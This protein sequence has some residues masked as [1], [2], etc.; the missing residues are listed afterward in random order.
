M[1]G[2]R[3]ILHRKRIGRLLLTLAGL[4]LVW[5]LSASGFSLDRSDL[6]KALQFVGCASRNL[7]GELDQTVMV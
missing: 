3:H 7:L 2:T 5:L 4:A 1:T 6:E